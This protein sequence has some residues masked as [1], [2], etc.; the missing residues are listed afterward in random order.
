MVIYGTVHHR[1]DNVDKDPKMCHSSVTSCL[2][3]APSQQDGALIRKTRILHGHVFAA[4][5]Y[6]MLSHKGLCTQ[7]GAGIIEPCQTASVLRG[8]FQR[9]DLIIAVLPARQFDNYESIKII[10]ISLVLHYVRLTVIGWIVVH[11]T[12]QIYRLQ[13]GNQ[14]CGASLVNAISGW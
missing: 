2:Y 5:W 10:N 13:K 4:L 3:V 8:P 14:L 11:G 12:W 6:G 7:Y 1:Q 9:I